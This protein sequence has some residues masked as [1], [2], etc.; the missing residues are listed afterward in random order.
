MTSDPAVAS[1]LR[2]N[3][4]FQALSSVPIR[5]G[6]DTY[7][8]RGFRWKVI[9]Q[10]DYADKLKLDAI[11]ANLIDFDSLDG[12]FLKK[13]KEY[14]D[15]LGIL[16]E[17]GFG[18]IG[19]LSNRWNPRQGDPAKYLLEVVRVTRAL[20]AKAAKVYMGNAAD[21]R[22]PVPIRAQ[23][24]ATLKGLRAVRPQVLDAGMRIAV[25]N[26]GDLRAVE[27]RALI[28]EAGKD[29]VGCCFDSGNPTGVLEDPLY[30]LE[31]LG[32]YTVTTHIRDTAVYE[33][34]RGAAVQPVAMG[35]GS[36]DFRALTARFRQ[37]C[38]QAP[39]LL[40]VIT[41]SAPSVVPYFEPDFWKAFPDTPASELARFV[42]LAR[43][44]R[45][46]EGSMMIGQRGNQPPEYEAALREQQRVDLER[47]LEYCKKTLDLGIRWRA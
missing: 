37:I 36:I 44:G 45:P 2:C 40:E 34:P 20:G 30:S 3:V 39:I 23:I 27:L 9:Q 21:R 41:G 11:Q 33:H 31:V 24:E 29:F 46:F 8:I 16:V 12:A 6:T 18:C 42:A 10:L 25:E 43:K 32:P 5:L 4:S 38:P 7:T 14:A 35:D 47:S 15:R 28:E 26:H 1:K 22:G 19:P 17:P 13:V